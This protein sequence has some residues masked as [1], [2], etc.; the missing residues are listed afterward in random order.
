M[1]PNDPSWGAP[2]GPAPHGQPGQP[3]QPGYGGYDPGGHGYGPGPGGPG[4]QAKLPG[5]T[6]FL[7]VTAILL[8]VLGTC[9]GGFGVISA[10][11][12]QNAADQM[13]AMGT[14]QGGRMGGDAPDMSQTFERMAALQEANAVPT[15]LLQFVA[16][17]A[18]LCLL[19]VGILIL[20]RNPRAPKLGVTLLF[21]NAGVSTL[22]TI[23][24][25]WLQFRTM[26]MM[27]E[28]FATP[29]TPGMGEMMEGMMGFG[30]AIA[31]AC[32]GGWLLLKLGFVF[33]GA[34]HLRKPEI[35][36]L[37]GGPQALGPRGE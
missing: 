35:A 16:F 27:G 13:R 17:A 37:F 14:L 25:M 24:E 31:L 33:W 21:T 15:A 6:V 32:G 5:S 29:D 34:A 3:G 11:N 18:A 26:N 28:V 10:F 1:Q 12:Q 9:V 7:A 4:S 19:A 8:G 23:G 22:G 20:M 2:G 30:I 36:G